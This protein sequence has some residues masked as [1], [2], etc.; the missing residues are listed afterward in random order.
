M[1]AG[2]VGNTSESTRRQDLATGKTTRPSGNWRRAL[3]GAANWE[4]GGTS[5][6]AATPGSGAGTPAVLGLQ[7]GYDVAVLGAISLLSFKQFC[8]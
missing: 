2:D 6:G 1:K 3:L 5:P 4:G 7:S 8:F